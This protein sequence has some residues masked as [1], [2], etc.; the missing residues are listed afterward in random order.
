MPLALKQDY[1]PDW[2]M[3]PLQKIARAPQ[4]LTEK[5]LSLYLLKKILQ[6]TCQVPLIHWRDLARS[7]EE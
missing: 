7:K 2:C 6:E 5:M 4:Q 3:R 1:D